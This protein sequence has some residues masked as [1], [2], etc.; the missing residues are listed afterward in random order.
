MQ[1]AQRLAQRFEHQYGG[2]SQQPKFPRPVNLDFCSATTGEP[3]TPC[4]TMVRHTLDHMYWE[5]C[6]TTWVAVFT[7]TAPIKSGLCLILKRCSMITLSWRRLYTA[8]HWRVSACFYRARYPELY[9]KRNDEP[10]R[11]FFSATDADSPSPDGHDEE[12]SFYLDP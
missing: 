11:P 6:M 10:T 4:C 12:D 3:K 8:F 7:A 9:P 1:T 2:F 5:E